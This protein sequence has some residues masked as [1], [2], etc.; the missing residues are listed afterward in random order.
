MLKAPL[1]ERALAALCR[2]LGV[3][4][5]ARVTGLDRSGIEVACAVRPNGHV[6]QVCNGKGLGW[7]RARASAVLEA[8]ELW[9]AERV[10]PSRL[11]FGSRNE[12]AP[13]LGSALW[14]PGDLGS[15]GELAA[16]ELWSD[17]TRIAW[18]AARELFTGEEVLVPAQALYCPPQSSVPLGPAVVRWT[19]NG[20]GAHPQEAPA[21][22]HALL[23]AIERDQLARALP[24]GWTAAEVRRRK[25][26]EPT[27]PQEL[28]E[29]CRQLAGRDFAV[30][31]FDLSP[32]EG[33][34][35]LPVAGALLVDRQPGPLPITAGYACGLRPEEALLGALLEA[36]QSRL[37]DIH[38]ARDD[39]VAPAL[40]QAHRL[41]R[42]CERAAGERSARKMAR[43]P[44]RSADQ[45][46]AQVLR[47][48]GRVGISR[49]AAVDLA[50]PE[51]GI[52]VIK[53]LIPGM[54]VSELL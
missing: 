49:A 21:M 14:D 29:L 19:S 9:A 44:A 24:S 43:V 33:A 7:E 8:A 37:T 22:L 25:L 40:E 48:L 17:D 13:R 30:H 41:A 4:R 18:M 23:E 38:G 31:L 53:V 32:E 42:I 52:H 3:S 26:A 6:L 15:A 1:T 28:S 16:P 50:P 54:Q 45:A 34:V 39:V 2:S 5:V 46:V 27:L 10:N 12:L 35:G 51:L 11:I 36:A 47:R 20:S